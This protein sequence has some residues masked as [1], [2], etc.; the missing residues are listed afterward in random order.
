[1]VWITKTSFHLLSKFKTDC[2]CKNFDNFEKKYQKALENSIK[3]F[4]S[5]ENQKRIQLQQEVI[6]L[7]YSW[8]T[9]SKEWISFFEEARKLKA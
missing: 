1:M 6:N 7:T 4:W 3:N 8:T 5:K 9:R 2:Y